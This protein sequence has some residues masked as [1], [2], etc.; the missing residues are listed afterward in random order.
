MIKKTIKRT[1]KAFRK[2]L[3]APGMEHVARLD[4]RFSLGVPEQNGV[5]DILWCKN[6]VGHARS[7]EEVKGTYQ[8][9][10]YILA[11]GPSLTDFDL[12][13]LGDHKSMG[14]NGSIV[15][16]RDSSILPEFYVILDHAF[17]RKRF[18]LIKEIITSKVKCFFS[19]RALCVIAVQDSTLLKSGNIYLIPGVNDS[20]DEAVLKDES[21]VERLKLEKA[22]FLPKQDINRWVGFSFDICKGVFPGRTVAFQCVQIAAYLGF[23]QIYI[24][25]MDLGAPETGRYRFYEDIIKEE[26]LKSNLDKNYE[27]IKAAFTCAV[28]ACESRGIELYNLSASSRLPESVMKKMTFTESLK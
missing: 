13:Q 1:R 9:K 5:R 18:F 17:I 20:F 24:A 12:M 8:G 26:S 7:P 22:F 6:V 16:Y 23:K 10:T 2:M 27:K 25:G 21:L 3:S 4:P 28:P 14:M 11:N 15:K 19:Y